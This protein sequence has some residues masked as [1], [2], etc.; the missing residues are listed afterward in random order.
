MVLDVLPPPIQETTWSSIACSQNH[1][2]TACIP[3]RANPYAVG[4]F[5]EPRPS[6]LES[7]AKGTRGPRLWPAPLGFRQ[8]RQPPPVRRRVG[9]VRAPC[10]GPADGFARR[11]DEPRTGGQGSLRHRAASAVRAAVRRCPQ[12]N[13]LPS[14]PH[15]QHR[16]T[17]RSGTVRSHRLG[18]VKIDGPKG[19]HLRKYRRLPPR[20]GQGLAT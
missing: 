4:V 12:V 10:H 17:S 16:W 3:G 20:S 1:P 7:S 18:G 9:A 5:R 15:E 13:L 8:I 14:Q 19:P 2:P 6:D 11:P